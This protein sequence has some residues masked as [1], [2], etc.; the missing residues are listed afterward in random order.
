MYSSILPIN[1]FTSDI[2][3]VKFGLTSVQAGDLYGYIYL[4]SGPTL[5]FVG[6]FNDSRG[7]ISLTQILAGVTALLGNLWWVLYPSELCLLGECGK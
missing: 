6:L 7:H 5:I 3:Q 1:N 4:V 2:L